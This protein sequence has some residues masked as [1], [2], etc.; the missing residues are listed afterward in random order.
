M[1][2]RLFSLAIMVFMAGWLQAQTEEEL[3]ALKAEKQA[4]VDALNGEI[5]DIDAK[6]DALPGWDL[7]TFGT[8][9][10]NASRF[11]NWF[12]G[13]NPNASSKAL[14]FTLNSFA[15]YDDPKMFWRNNGGINL[16]WQALDLDAN[17]VEAN[18]TGFEQ[19]ADIL[20]INSLYG[21]KL[22]DAVAISAMLDYNTSLLTNF[23]N[24]GI[25]DI[26]AGAT[27]TPITNLVIAVHPLNYHIVMG[28]NPAFG[29]ALGTK[30]MADYTGEILPGL[31]WKSNFSAFMPYSSQDPNPSLGE[32]TWTN[33]FG[34]SI[35]KG[36][37][38]GLE[39]GLRKAEVESADTQR[40]WVL[41][42]SYAI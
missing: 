37:G 24:P 6:I 23:N 36:I 41:G 12:K 32:W 22:S 20:K 34:L 7:G 2:Y 42:L 38:I 8:I 29:S 3:V 16:G 26:G 10:F 18:E 30:L 21:Y 17:V 5:A 15:N 19:V 28:D 11:D 9:G 1:N 13:A 27:F 35:V 31:S 40:F 14:R 33:G 25:L 39:F 4:A